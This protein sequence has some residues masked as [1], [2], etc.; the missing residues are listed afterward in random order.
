MM[1]SDA[2]DQWEIIEFPAILPSGKPLWPGYWPL[3]ELEQIK[4]SISPGKWSAE[5]MQN[6][7]G[8][9]ASIINQSGLKFG[10]AKVHHR[11]NI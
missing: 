1:E 11:S 9:G 5:Y 2:A 4:A 10:I 6:P 7:T 8:E 3:P